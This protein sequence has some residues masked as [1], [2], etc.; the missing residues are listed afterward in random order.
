MCV[1]LSLWRERKQSTEALKVSLVVLVVSILVRCIPSYRSLF[2]SKVFV[3]MKSGIK[4]SKSRST[5]RMLSLEL[6]GR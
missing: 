5:S 3:N 1:Q 6:P 4:L 2:Q